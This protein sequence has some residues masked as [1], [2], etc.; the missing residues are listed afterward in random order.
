MEKRSVYRL[1]KNRER[2]SRDLHQVKCVKDEKVLINQILKERTLTMLFNGHK[3]LRSDRL[4]N[5]FITPF[6]AE[7][8]SLWF[9]ETFKRYGRD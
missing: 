9:K 7:R 8:W 4:M 3:F 1:A 5:I 2:K 6:I